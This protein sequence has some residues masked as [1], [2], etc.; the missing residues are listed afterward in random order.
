[1]NSL[2]LSFTLHILGQVIWLGPALILPIALIPAIRSL[3]PAVQTRFM[4]K[5]WKMYF[6][7]FVMGGILVGVTGWYQY[8]KMAGGINRP[9]IIAKHVVIL[10][11][12]AASVWIWVFVARKL[13]KP[14]EDTSRQWKM[15]VPLSWVQLI[16]AVAVFVITGWLTE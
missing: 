2:G 4:A 12:I 10:P 13:S 5:F 16:L 1:M 14:A 8:A 6:P 9:I 15:L 3:E 11:L 7:M